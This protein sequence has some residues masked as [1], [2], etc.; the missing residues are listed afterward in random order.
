MLWL[1]PTN[2]KLIE[3]K[4]HPVVA[5]PA[6]AKEILPRIS[7]IAR[8]RKE[9]FSI[10]AIREIRGEKSSQKW[11]ILTYSGAESRRGK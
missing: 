3:I 11:S 4:A 10:R 1:N 8:I 5:R 7:R 9:A 6:A 2:K